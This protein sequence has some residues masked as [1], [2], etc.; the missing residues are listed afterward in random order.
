MFFI[1]VPMATPPNTPTVTPNERALSI[2]LHF[3]EAGIFGAKNGKSYIGTQ[4]RSFILYVDTLTDQRAAVAAF[5]KI[6]DATK[7]FYHRQNLLSECITWLKTKKD[8]SAN[9]V[10]EQ[11]LSTPYCHFSISGLN[12]KYLV[13]NGELVGQIDELTAEGAG[14]ATFRTLLKMKIVDEKIAKIP[15]G[16][17][18]I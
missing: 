12:G 11:L 14:E 15:T 17:A 9:E 1:L 18:F 10:N 6:S 8:A 5:Y 4:D 16:V 13:Y 2:L 7:S 3:P